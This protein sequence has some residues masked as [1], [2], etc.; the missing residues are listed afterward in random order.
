MRNK[1]GAIW[2]GAI[3]GLFLF[4][5]GVLFIPFMTDDV[6]TFRDEMDCSNSSISDG[7][8]L[9]CLQGDLLIPYVIWF[10]TSMALGLFVGSKI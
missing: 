7:A 4:V 6:T 10:F 1:K 2:F 3:M 8:K 5:M 9:S